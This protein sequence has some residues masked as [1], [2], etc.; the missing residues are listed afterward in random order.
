VNG[1]VVGT[2]IVRAIEDGSSA[3]DRIGR[4]EALVGSLRRGLDSAT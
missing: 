4:V 3:E 2:A 1:V